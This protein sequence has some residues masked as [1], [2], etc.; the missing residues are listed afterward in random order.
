MSLKILISVLDD[1]DNMIL[2]RQ[3]Q[4]PIQETQKNTKYPLVPELQNEIETL[5]EQALIKI[6]KEH[7][8]NIN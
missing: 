5:A 6:N 1:G 8:G 4:V 2:N 3:Y 7:N